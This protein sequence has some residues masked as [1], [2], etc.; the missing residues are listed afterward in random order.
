[1]VQTGVVLARASQGSNPSASIS[2]QKTW[3]YG[4]GDL[5]R[6]E[7]TGIGIRNSTSSSPVGEVSLLSF[8]DSGGGVLE[9]EVGCVDELVVKFFCRRI[10]ICWCDN[11]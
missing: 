6:I 8:L 2:L 1:M 4:Y 10:L 3:E 5:D 9:G 7:R 11:T